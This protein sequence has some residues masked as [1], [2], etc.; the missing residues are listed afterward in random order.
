MLFT[1]KTSLLTYRIE[2]ELISS[3]EFSSMLWGK[4][5]KFGVIYYDS[6]NFSLPEIETNLNKLEY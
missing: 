5:G 2:L 3:F 1:L 6:L 4:H